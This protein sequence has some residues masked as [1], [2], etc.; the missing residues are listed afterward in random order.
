MVKSETERI[1]PAALS[2]D[3]ATFIAIQALG[4]YQPVKSAFCK[5]A[6]AVCH[7]SLRRAHEAEVRAENAAA[8]ARDDAAAAE[9]DF[10]DLIQGAKAQVIAQYGTDS[11]EVQSLGL[12]KR[13]ENKASVRRPAK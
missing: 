8:A 3:E 6:L 10:H 13:S 1:R 2:D 9:W 4:S 7:S 12:K 5:D 11:N